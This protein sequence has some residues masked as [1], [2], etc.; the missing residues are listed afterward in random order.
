MSEKSD[1]EQGYDQAMRRTY[2]ERIGAR[3]RIA[4]LESR[5]AELEGEKEQLIA[6]AEKCLEWHAKFPLGEESFMQNTSD[7]I[8]MELRWLLKKECEE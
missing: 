6:I 3:K 2:D 7:E 5:I 8:Y 1:W 4:E